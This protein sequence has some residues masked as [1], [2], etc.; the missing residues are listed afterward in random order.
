MHSVIDYIMCY[1]TSFLLG[2]FVGGILVGYIKDMLYRKQKIMENRM[3]QIRRMAR[4]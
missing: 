2:S 3:K 4:L 1:G